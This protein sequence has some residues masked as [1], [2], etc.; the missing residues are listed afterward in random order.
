MVIIFLTLLVIAFAVACIGGILE[1]TTRFTKA[2]LITAPAFYIS[3][4]LGAAEFLTLIIEK[5]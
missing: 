1:K 3:E 2:K 5:L 4:A